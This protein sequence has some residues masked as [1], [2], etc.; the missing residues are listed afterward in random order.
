M[1]VIIGTDLHKRSAT[2]EAIDPTGRVLAI[3]RY[4]T[5]NLVAPKC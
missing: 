2:I 4:T 1:T 3:G 5:G